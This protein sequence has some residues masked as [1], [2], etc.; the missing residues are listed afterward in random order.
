MQWVEFGF[1][2]TEKFPRPHNSVTTLST[3]KL[4]TDSA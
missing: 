3:T 4:Y 1:C 2:K